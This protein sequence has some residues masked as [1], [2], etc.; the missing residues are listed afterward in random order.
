MGTRTLVTVTSARYGLSLPSTLITTSRY[1]TFVTE[2]LVTVCQGR[3]RIS[4]MGEGE[5]I[6]NLVDEVGEHLA[7][8]TIFDDDEDDMSIFDEE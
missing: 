8:L 2:S 5:I 4:K 7:R 6:N 1:G 3:A